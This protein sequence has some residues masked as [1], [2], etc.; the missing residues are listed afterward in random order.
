MTKSGD[1]AGGHAALQ[2]PRK[3]PAKRN[4]ASLNRAAPQ[5]QWN[6]NTDATTAFYRFWGHLYSAF[7]SLLQEV[8]VP[9]ITTWTEKIST[10]L[11]KTVG[12]E[13]QAD[14]IT[15]LHNCI[16]LVSGK[17]RLYYLTITS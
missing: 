12:K 3:A 6:M 10:N 11:R 5:R 8:A 9:P 2:S 17:I 4:A 14:T 15:I 1:G 16:M 13:P 7:Y